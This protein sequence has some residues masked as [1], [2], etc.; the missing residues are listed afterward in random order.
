M[1]P[2]HYIKFNSVVLFALW[3]SFAGC[4]VFEQNQPS[5][6]TRIDNS[7]LIST[8]TPAIEQLYL[9]WNDLDQKYKDIKFIER[10]YLSYPDDTQLG[11]CQKVA[12]YVQDASVRI[13][14]NWDRLSVI[15]YIRPEKMPDY[16]TLTVRSL[17]DDIG[18]IDYDDKFITLYAA[19][20]QN[21]AVR[22]EIEQAQDLIRESVETLIE[23]KEKILPYTNTS[24]GEIRI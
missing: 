3:V 16:L 13:H 9:T 17:L 7:E 6:S 21:E 15:H 23:I 8:I 18:E 12:L 2:R 24:A 5:Q 22:K 19:F 14:H 10:G 1:K 20:M 4:A 11:Y